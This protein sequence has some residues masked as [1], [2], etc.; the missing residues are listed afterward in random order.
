MTALSPGVVTIS[1][2]S[3]F[4]GN[5]TNGY[6]FNNAADNTNLMILK[7]NGDLSVGTTGT[8]HRLFVV[9]T[10]NATQ[11]NAQLR[12]A[13]SGYSAFHF[14]DAT[15]YNIG[16]NSNSR[17]LRIYSGGNTG[18]GVQLAAGANSFGTFSDERLKENIEPI[19]G[20][21]ESLSGLRTVKYHLK[22]I[23]TSESKKRLGLLAQDLVGVLDEVIE[24]TTQAGDDTEYMAVRYTEII[25][26]LVK[27]IQ[28]QQAIIELQAT[29][30]TDLT[31]RLTALE[32]N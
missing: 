13:G 30:I 9:N 26:V 8:G 7:D 10:I 31:T 6:R 2:G 5:A 3:Y 22:D 21:I 25:P 29:A 16:Q 20:A 27:G 1:S 4:I 32:N 24:P 17:V 11:S 12:V 14:L 23:D 15:A 18:V 28:E 19:E